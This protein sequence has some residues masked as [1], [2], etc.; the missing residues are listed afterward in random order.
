MDSLR[1]SIFSTSA[2]TAKKF[3]SLKN[4]LT[5]KF[6]TSTTNIDKVTVFVRMLQGWKNH[7]P[8]PEVPTPG[9]NNTGSE[10]SFPE[11]TFKGRRLGLL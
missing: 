11:K 9:D 4:G 6:K 3:Q 5:S 10:K 7:G 8:V 2:N 1:D